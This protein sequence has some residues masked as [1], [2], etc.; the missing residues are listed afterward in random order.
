MSNTQ[1]A[2]LA[3]D[4]AGLPKNDPLWTRAQ[5]F[6]HR[7]QNVN[8]QIT[9]NIEGSEY[10]VQPY[11]L[12][13]GY[14][15]GFIYY[16]G[17][18]LAGGQVSYGSM[19]GAG[20]WG[21]LL[22]GVP[23]TDARVVAAVSWVRN[24]YTWDT[25]PGIGWWRT[26]YYYLSMSK[27]L[28]MYGQ[29]LIDGHY[30]FQELYDKIVGMQIDSGSGQGY[31]STSNEDHAPDLTTAYAILSLQT[32]AATPPV[33]RLSYLT[34]ILRSNCLI[35]ILDPDVNLVGYNYM[36][37]LGEN[38]IPTAVYSGPFSE[39][40]YIVIVNPRPGTY[41]LELVG[42]SEGPYTLTIQGS[43]GEKVTKTYEFA[44]NIRPGDLLSSNVLVTAIVGP[45]DVYADKPQT[46]DRI[47]PSTILVLGAP[48]YTDPDNDIFVSS[49]TPFT[50]T[51]T[52]NIDGSGVS[53][54]FYRISNSTYDTGQ[55]QYF[56]SFYLTSLADGEYSIEYYSVDNAQNIETAHSINVTLFSW[57]Y[58]FQD[59]FGRGTTLKINTALRLFEFKTPAAD[60]GVRTATS[61]R[62]KGIAIIVEHKDKELR[63]VALAWGTTVNFCIANSWDMKTFKN[64]KLID[65]GQ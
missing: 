4:A 32:R 2:L 21:L 3:L 30:W 16:P 25:N 17:A 6:L 7:T 29:P 48:N 57:N 54:T 61:M 10:A 18:S 58:I 38:Q 47:S 64:C 63:L 46:V 13:G 43:Y 11:N 40:Q 62:Q 8:F 19:T 23:K 12:Y 24:H 44:G 14:D 33:Q 50:L 9:L 51:A 15:G 31:W 56:S 26:Y 27:A 65:K 20:I 42:V 28:T 49:T 55:M 41:K 59:T 35:R 60:Y 37:G 5:V 45:I 22:S 52:D 53:A 1:F 39:P 36:T 34:F